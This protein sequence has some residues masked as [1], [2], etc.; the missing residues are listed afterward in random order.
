MRIRDVV[1]GLATAAGLLC[2][3]VALLTTAV[4]YLPPSAAPGAPDTWGMLTAFTD[5]GLAGYLVALALLAVGLALRFTRVR[6]AL[7]G[8]TL[9]L[10]LLHASWIGPWFVAA[11]APAAAGPTFRILAANLYFGRAD[12]RTVVEAGREADVLVLT[13][14]TASARDRLRALG[15]DRDFP[16]EA[17]G[18][19]P[20]RGAIGTLVLSRFP[21]TGLQPLP[22][23]VEHQNWLVTVDAPGIGAVRLAAVHPSPPLRGRSTWATDHRLLR[24]ALA[25]ESGPV[26]VSGDFNAVPSHWPMRRLHADGFR[27]SVDLAGA[28]WQPTWPT[29]RHRLPPVVSIDHVLLSRQ[30]TATA[31]GTVRLPGSDHLG[32]TA[33]VTLR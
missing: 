32:V 20:D 19:L 7:L 2:A 16:H 26:I 17:G 23:A 1:G 28:G 15:I 25:R 27:T 22:T 33:T 31:A 9:A 6:T 21:L 8:V 29:G 4:R 18:R 30:L 14:I 10:S 5:F 13:E 3:A 12:A 11:P 24:E